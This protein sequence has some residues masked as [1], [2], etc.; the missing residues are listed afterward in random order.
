MS[1]ALRL[2]TAGLTRAQARTRVGAD[3]RSAKRRGGAEPR[4]HE[5]PV[6]D[7]GEGRDGID[8]SGQEHGR[9]GLPDR[10]DPFGSQI[11]EQ[12]RAA[13]PQSHSDLAEQVVGERVA[14]MVQGRVA[15]G[16]ECLEGHIADQGEA[17]YAKIVAELTMRSSSTAT[18]SCFSASPTVVHP[19]DSITPTANNLDRRTWTDPT[20]DPGGIGTRNSNLADA[21]DEVPGRNYRPCAL[22][23]VV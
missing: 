13:A 15:V 7:L 6:E 10:Q 1:T 22:D 11:T 2:R 3:A 17:N 20:W 23:P 8:V 9:L 16:V 4:M 19:S 18:R 12:F 5:I 21:A 14:G